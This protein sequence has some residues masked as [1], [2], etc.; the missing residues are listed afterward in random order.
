MNDKGWVIMTK[1]LSKVAGTVVGKAV[2]H[3]EQVD[4]KLKGKLKNNKVRP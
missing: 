2:H 3:D 1:L 4:Y